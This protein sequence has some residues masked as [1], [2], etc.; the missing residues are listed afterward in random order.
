MMLFKT[1]PLVLC[2]GRIELE[3][4]TRRDKEEIM[5]STNRAKVDLGSIII[6]GLFSI[7]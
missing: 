3:K 4:P 2:G 6:Y 5:V 7:Q 1:T